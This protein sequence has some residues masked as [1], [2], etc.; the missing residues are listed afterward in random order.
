M[1]KTWATMMAT[2]LCSLMLL[3]LFIYGSAL[4]SLN[5]GISSLV[6]GSS[7]YNINIIWSPLMCP[8]VPFSA[9]SPRRSLQGITVRAS[10]ILL[11]SSLP[12]TGGDDPITIID[13]SSAS[14]SGSIHNLPKY[15]F[16]HMV[17]ENFGIRKEPR[18]PIRRILQGL[19]VSD[20]GN[21]T[22]VVRVDRTVMHKK[23]HKYITKSTR[24]MAHDEHNKQRVGD[25][26]KIRDCRPISRRKFFE[27]FD[28]GDCG[29]IIKSSSISS[30]NHES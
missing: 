20:K 6:K 19:V 21:K 7:W 24:I 16:T 10:K 4:L 26:V 15:E 23:Y 28:D 25:V 18:Q 5:R 22:I 14:Y 3:Q 11:A 9:I 13:T 1:E 8:V 30:S 29:D 17:D 12:E 27:T 2:V